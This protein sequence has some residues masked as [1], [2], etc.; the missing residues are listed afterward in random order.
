MK[1]LFFGDVVGR[2]GREILKSGGVGIIKELAPDFVIANGENAAGGLGLDLGTASE[3]LGIGIDL[4]TT[5]NHIWQRKDLIS[6][7]KDP[8]KPILRPANFPKECPGAG[9]MIFDGPNGLKLGVM[10]L[11]ARV[12]MSQEV[13]CPFRIADELLKNELKECSHIFVDFHGE[14]SSE[15][16]ALARYL[17]GRVSAVVCTHTHVQTA[18]ETIIN[19]ET[20]YITDVGMCGPSDSII[21]VK[22]EPII[23]KFLT[24]MP[25]KFEVATGPAQINAVEIICS[26][27]CLR[28]T[29]IRRIFERF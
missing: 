2:P 10:N 15:K 13:D 16:M 29:S 28:A 26:D 20:A 23:K 19:N 3:L 9:H 14:A 4:L 8:K 17:S 1:I 5:G 18:D 24:S 6:V 27:D 25:Q 12:F 22:P 7:L 21:G 11:I